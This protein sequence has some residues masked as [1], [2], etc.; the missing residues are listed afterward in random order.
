MATTNHFEEVYGTLM[1]KKFGPSLLKRSAKSKKLPFSASV[2]QLRNVDLM[3]QYEECEMWQLLY[4]SQK[5]WPALQKQPSTI[6][7]DYTCACG[8]ILSDF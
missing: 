8:A 2:Q 6:L 3:L 5:L 4:S 1:T 7:E